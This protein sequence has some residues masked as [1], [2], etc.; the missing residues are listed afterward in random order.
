VQQLL[1]GSG[2][3]SLKLMGAKTGSKPF[4]GPPSAH[5]RSRGDQSLPT[6]RLLS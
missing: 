1:A 4:S 6:G 2:A 5:I 3:D